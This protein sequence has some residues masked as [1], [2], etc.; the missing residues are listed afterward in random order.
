MFLATGKSRSALPDLDKVLQLKPDF[1][2]VNHLLFL[3]KIKMNMK[4]CLFPILQKFS[5]S[6]ATGECFAETMRTGRRICGL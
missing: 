5:G 3:E 1:T 6:S 4:N 2:S